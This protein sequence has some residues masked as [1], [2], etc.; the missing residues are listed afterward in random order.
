M[1]MEIRIMEPAAKVFNKYKEMAMLPTEPHLHGTAFN[2]PG[3][4]E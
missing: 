2:G 4:G 3:G 1:L